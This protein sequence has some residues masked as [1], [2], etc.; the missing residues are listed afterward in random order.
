MLLQ[1]GRGRAP[2]T[3]RVLVHYQLETR[4][5]RV[6]IWLFLWH[7][8]AGECAAYR[9]VT[10]ELPVRRIYRL[11]TMSARRT[12]QL[13]AMSIIY[14]LCQIVRD[15]AFRNYLKWLLCINSLRVPAR[16]L[17]RFNRLVYEQGANLH[18]NDFDCWNITVLAHVWLQFV[19]VVIFSATCCVLFSHRRR[20]KS[21]QNKHNHGV[22]SP[23]YCN[24]AD[25]GFR[26]G[27]TTVR[28][29]AHLNENNLFQF[30][31]FYSCFISHAQTALKD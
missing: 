10:Q 6:S 2:A 5:W 4:I 9:N 24:F 14:I 20:Q 25:Y 13:T 23:T 21:A 11:R 31:L 8:E 27:T 26:C 28:L 1:R 7:F 3:I 18:A 17:P 22:S 15:I 16:Q 29:S 12:G 30:W 19:G